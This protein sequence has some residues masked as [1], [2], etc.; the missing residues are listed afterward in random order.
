VSQPFEGRL[1]SE[2]VEAQL[3]AEIDLQLKRLLKAAKANVKYAA[4]DLA[5]EFDFGTP[6]DM[7]KAVRWYKRAAEAGDERAMVNLGFAYANGDGVR[8]NLVLALYWYRRAARRGNR[9]AIDNLAE[10]R[11]L[12]GGVSRGSRK[13]PDGNRH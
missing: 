2:E 12:E 5:L 3:L 4:C 7:K 8:R 11:R 1:L 9:T 13:P 6:R 10:L